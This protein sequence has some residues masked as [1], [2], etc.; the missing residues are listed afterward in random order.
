MTAHPAP[1]QLPL[2][3]PHAASYDAADLAE[4]M[5]QRIANPAWLA[6]GALVSLETSGA[7]PQ[8]PEGLTVEAERRFGKAFLT[9]YRFPA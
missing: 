1:R 3:L 9:L 2:P 4:A 6:P 5:L 8:P 7:G